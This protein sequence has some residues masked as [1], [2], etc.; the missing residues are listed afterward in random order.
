MWDNQAQRPRL[1]VAPDGAIEAVRVV[2]APG[3][4]AGV[5]WYPEYDMETDAVSRRIF[6]SF[7]DAVLLHCRRQKPVLRYGT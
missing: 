3:F 4:A 6:M 5:Q 1:K 7:G 2:N